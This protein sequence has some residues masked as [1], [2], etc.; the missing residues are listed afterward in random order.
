[1]SQ[2]RI[3]TCT[4]SPGQGCV[5]GGRL[6]GAS[7]TTGGLSLADPADTSAASAVL[8]VH[9]IVS[10]AAA[11]SSK[12]YARKGHI[13]VL[14]S[15][16]SQRTL[17][18]KPK[19]L[20][21]C[22]AGLRSGAGDGRCRLPGRG[23]GG[24]V[25]SDRCCRT[26]S[27]QDD[28][29]AS[30]SLCLWLRVWL[31]ELAQQC[32]TGKHNARCFARQKPSV[33]C[34]DFSGANASLCSPSF[35]CASCLS[36]WEGTMAAVLET[37]TRAQMVTSSQACPCGSVR[38]SNK[39]RLIVCLLASGH[40]SRWLCQTTMRDSTR[41]ANEHMRPDDTAFEHRLPSAAVRH[42]AILVIKRDPSRRFCL[43]GPL[44]RLVATQPEAVPPVA[45]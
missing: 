1:M 12:S 10:I 7:S 34:Y 40:V 43:Q 11:T 20:R 35:F 6:S 18:C 17:C 41:I 26:L 45:L 21:Y 33:S 30:W 37:F 24:A 31:T 29:H 8:T 14:R 32:R 42:G 36:V 15:G 39:V 44:W 19:R 22:V 13:S 4:C 23:G 5:D 3:Q 16:L 27:L 9:A 38:T 2:R 28:S 25:Q